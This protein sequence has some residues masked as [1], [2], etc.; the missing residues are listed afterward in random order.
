MEW[1]SKILLQKHSRCPPSISSSQFR[2]PQ[3]FGDSLKAL[4]VSALPR[5]CE[6]ASDA[7]LAAVCCCLPTFSDR[8]PSEGTFSHRRYNSE[9]KRPSYVVKRASES[10][11]RDG[12]SARTSSPPRS[13]IKRPTTQTRCR[14]TT[15]CANDPSSRIC[16]SDP[17]VMVTK[18][19]EVDP[20]SDISILAVLNSTDQSAT[21]DGTPPA[22]Y[23]T[24]GK[25]ILS[26]A[27]SW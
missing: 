24:A 15:I 5:S 27:W 19:F 1:N 16:W 17:G 22:C 8:R 3:E 18:T 9:M 6:H 4:S 13:S 21:L 7:V 20:P 10:T 26:V 2:L 11:L 23:P 25:I 12:S 14:D